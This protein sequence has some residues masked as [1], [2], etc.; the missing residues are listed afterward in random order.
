MNLFISWSGSRSKAVAEALHSWLPNVI[1]SVR[2]WLSAADLEKGARWSSDI[3]RQLQDTRVGI[4]CLT[5][6][7]LVAPWILFEAGALS[8]TLE[9]TFVCPYLFH[10]EP[11]ELKGPLV[12]FQAT[13]AEKEETRKLVH[14]INAALSTAS[15]TEKHLNEAFDI[16]W[17]RLE[18]QLK[19]ISDARE[20]P[21]SRRTDRELIE[22][23]LEL[24]RDLARTR[25]IRSQ[26][27]MASNAAIAID[28]PSDA[29]PRNLE[30]A[31]TFIKN[32]QRLGARTPVRAA[33]KPT[34][35]GTAK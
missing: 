15:L 17:P 8:K 34:T 32:V 33:K 28:N 21:R 2:P 31:I 13:K 5:S 29:V 14:T 11:A 20:G 4:I 18:T 24:T 9:S 16:W 6:D 22:E 30:D 12:Q 23:I 35:R 7:N 10:V 1:Q 26:L 27:P 3:A 25:L 19:S